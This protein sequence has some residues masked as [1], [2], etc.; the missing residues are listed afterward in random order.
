M[1]ENYNMPYAKGRVV[2]LRTRINKIAM[3]LKV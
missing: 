2:T 3:V 1:F